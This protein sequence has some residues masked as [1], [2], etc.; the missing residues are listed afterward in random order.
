[1]SVVSTT[2]SATR[3][4]GWLNGKVGTTGPSSFQGNNDS[5]LRDDDDDEMMMIGGDLQVNPSTLEVDY[6]KNLTK[7]YQSITDQDWKLAASICQKDPI[8]AAVWVVRH[9]N[10]DNEENNTASVTSPEQEPEIMWR[11][12]PLHSACARQ[13]PRATIV[14]LLN[15]Y[16]DAAK[17]VDD[18]GMYA[19]HYACGNQADE[20]V[21]R[22]LLTVFSKA[23]AIP[24]PRGMLPL[25][26][27]ACWGPSSSAY[28]QGV[29]DQ[30][31]RAYPSAL[32]TR[33]LDGNTPLDLA[34][35]GDYPE[36]DA[37]AD[38][39][40]QWSMR[41]KTS[42]VSSS[43]AVST[44]SSGGVSQKKVIKERLLNIRPTGSH[45]SDYND[46]IFVDQSN[47][48]PLEPPA[49]MTPD[50]NNNALTASAMMISSS[51]APTP[52]QSSSPS[53]QQESRDSP[54][55]VQSKNFTKTLDKDNAATALNLVETVLSSSS[56]HKSFHNKSLEYDRDAAMCSRD[57]GTP[58]YDKL[59]DKDRHISAL[60]QE[61]K[62]TRAMLDESRLE[63]SGLRQSLGDLMEE[64]E[65]VKRK[66]GNTNDRLSSLSIS[67]NS[68]KEQ[69][70]IL[71][72]IVTKRNENCKNITLKRQAL[73]E[74]LLKMD[75]EVAE[76]ESHIDTSLKKQTREMEAISAVINAALD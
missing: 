52:R 8:Q 65:S 45:G 37:I 5:P 38:A 47:K 39:L 24:D 13:P 11:F 51:L 71:S 12:L 73:F 18:Q 53:Q 16:P 36:K 19:L 57:I 28:S 60:E 40:R 1:M 43:S 66:S 48:V 9:Y 76:E 32:A 50:P 61:L 31:I 70:S 35:D 3:S 67:L 29:L 27:T 55:L 58:E 21:I 26:Y 17:C 75:M 59:N 41:T 30:L 72:R 10:D 64:H 6:D 2:N 46:A 15:A 4:I 23:A 20:S 56:T 33:D 62:S 68:M 22:L 69:Q 49:S 74:Q 63:C 14:A 25:H 34:V 54:P 44:S 42:K 7:L